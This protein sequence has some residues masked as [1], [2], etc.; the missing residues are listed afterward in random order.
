MLATAP[1]VSLSPSAVKR[2]RMGYLVPE[3][4]AQPHTWIWRE[5]HAL[6]QAGIDAE[7][8]STRLPCGNQLCHAWSQSA[9]ER[10]TYLMPM[11]AGEVLQALTKWLFAGPREWWRLLRTLLRAEHVT[12]KQRLTLLALAL[13][14]A[15]LAGL[16][17]QRQW[18]HLHVL[19]PGNSANLALLCSLLS[20]LPYSINLV[21]PLEHFGGNQAQKWGQ[22]EFGLVMSQRLRRALREQLGSAAPAEIS[23]AP[24]GVDLARAQRNTP[25]QPWRGAGPLTIYT[26][27][28]L[29]PVKGH[30]YLIEAVA[31]LRQ[32]GLDVQLFIAGED[33]HAGAGYRLV[34]EAAIRE[35]GVT[36]AVQLLGATPE[37]QHLAWLERAHLFVLPSLD[38]GI[39]VSA[40]DAMA[41]ELPVIVTDCAAMNELVDPEGDALMVSPGSATELASAISRLAHDPELCQRLS[42]NSRQKIAA[43]FHSGVSAGA[44]AEQLS[45]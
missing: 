5:F 27:G 31:M 6:T 17:Q 19:N 34:T 23:V 18:R 26:C 30:V 20:G 45:G 43:R 3:F 44:I 8:V 2:V 15:K 4:P 38:E 33:E 40:M 16:A 29:N 13:P 36:G 41:L 9:R 28:R 35:H 22:A 12:F 1:E 21:G 37:D 24:L 10:T 39:A 7:F 32:Q 42:R 25:Y 11:S 14:A